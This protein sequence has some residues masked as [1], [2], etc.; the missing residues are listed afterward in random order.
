MWKWLL[1]LIGVEIS[2]SA[3]PLEEPDPPGSEKK[4]L[5]EL[6]RR[7]GV[8]KE[9]LVAVANARRNYRWHAIPKKDGGRRIVYTPQ[10]ELKDIQRRLLRKVFARLKVHPAACGFVRGRSVVDHAARHVGKKIVVKID[11]QEFFASTSWERVSTYL[12]RLGW[13]NRFGR[14]ESPNSCLMTLCCYANGLPQGA[15]T[16]P[17][18]SNAV[19]YRMD[20]RLAA[21]AARSGATYSRYADD[22]A[23][24][25]DIDDV[26]FIRGVIRRVRRILHSEGY[27]VHKAKLRYLRSHQQQRLVGLVVNEKVQLPRKTRRLLRAVEHRLGT[28]AGA[29][30]TRQ[31]LAGWRAY[32]KMIRAQAATA[33]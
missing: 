29:T 28:G 31:E 16:S 3:R 21:L 20:C 18:L 6:A 4:T 2:E 12:K 15:P 10:P 13:T 32:E 17:I 9:Q 14:R 11:I 23:F 30:M 7:V 19:N 5:D 22:M 25:F 27:R 26:R 24:S 1:S 8:S 33:G